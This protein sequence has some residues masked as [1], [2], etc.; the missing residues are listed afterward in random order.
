MKVKSEM[1]WL[2]I[3]EIHATFGAFPFAI[4]TSEEPERPLIEVYEPTFSTP[5]N[6]PVGD[7]PPVPAARRHMI[8]WWHWRPT[9]D[10]E[11]AYMPIHRDDPFLWK[12]VRLPDDSRPRILLE[13]PDNRHPWH[14]LRNKR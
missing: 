6:L 5:L 10:N 9:G 8:E 1:V 11:G 14:Y 13:R 3:K 4:A 12:V 2:V 7:L